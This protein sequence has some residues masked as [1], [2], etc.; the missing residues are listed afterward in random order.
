MIAMVIRDTIQLMM[1]RLAADVHSHCR[2]VNSRS[3]PIAVPST[4]NQ[5]TACQC[6]QIRTV[7]PECFQDD[8]ERRCEA[9]D[10]SP[11]RSKT[12]IALSRLTIVRYIADY[13]WTWLC[14]AR[15]DFVGFLLQAEKDDIW[16]GRVDRISAITYQ[17][18]PLP[19]L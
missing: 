2:P 1:Q 11:H 15:L 19:E 8:D 5:H 6:Y 7:V 17:F 4:T 16:H 10:L 18:S 9:R 3:C 14:Y 13:Q 12:S